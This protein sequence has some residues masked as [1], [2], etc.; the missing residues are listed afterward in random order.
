MHGEA[1]A[2]WAAATPPRDF[3]GW[4]GGSKAVVWGLGS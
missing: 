3:G 2:L 4:S 1:S